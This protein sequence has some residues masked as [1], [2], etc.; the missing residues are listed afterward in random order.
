MRP[1]RALVLTL[2][3]AIVPGCGPRPVE[4]SA[5]L[6]VGAILPLSGPES[7]RGT[8]VL[9]GMKLA[10]SLGER[11]HAV[12]VRAFDVEDS[13]SLAARRLES[14][15]L[16]PQV[17]GVVTGWSAATGRALAADPRRADLPLLILSPFAFPRRDPL[18]PRVILLHRLEALGAAAARFAHEDLRAERAGMIEDPSLEASRVLALAFD[19]TL[20]HYGGTLAWR[21]S[22]ENASSA[23]PRRERGPRERAR[24]AAAR[25]ADST[26]A[27]AQHPEAVV[28]V[29]APLPFLES[30]VESRELGA[31]ALIFPEGWA[32]PTND[33]PL[34]SEIPG[35]VVS[36]ASPADPDPSA[37]EFR[38]SCEREGLRPTDAAAFGWDASRL[39]QG[40]FADGARTREEVI[41]RL[42][43][44]G[45]QD[46]A[47]GK[48]PASIGEIAET[49]A[50]SSLTPSGWALRRR[51][52]T[53]P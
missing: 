44:R 3:L 28:F 52:P 4:T 5:P 10:F 8:Q 33:L 27:G 42:K 15:A 26:D 18:D 13:P 14:L 16:D 23:P 39:L 12:E 49:P 36:F 9:A 43:A 47:T 29:A 37:R 51:V 38:A 32:P 50:V 19:E 41:A 22:P 1:A 24:A 35:Y 53:R 45:V 31:S 20:M 34:L 48:I 7:E 30:L 6:V 46:G 2:G 40:A 25:A 17:L 11:A 21:I